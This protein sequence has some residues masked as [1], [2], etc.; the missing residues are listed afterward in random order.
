MSVSAI[1]Q[2]IIDEAR[3]YTTETEE[4]EIL[5]ELQHY[6]GTTNV[7]D[8]TTDYLTALFFAC[9][10]FPLEDGRVIMLSQQ[11]PMRPY[12]TEPRANTSRA[13][14]Q[15]SVFV[16]PPNGFIVPEDVVRIPSALKEPMLRYLHHCHSISSE[17][18]YNDLHGFIRQQN[19]HGDAYRELHLA[20]SYHKEHEGDL[21]HAIDHYTRAVALNPRLAQAY[22]GRG[23]AYLSKGELDRAIQDLTLCVEVE[24]DHSCAYALRGRAH[25]RKGDSEQALQ[26]LD[27]AIN[28]NHEFDN[29]TTSTAHFYRGTAHVEKGDYDEAISDFDVVIDRKLPPN[30]TG[31]Y[32]NRGVAYLSKGEIEQAVKDF[33]RTIELNPDESETFCVRGITHVYR[34]D[35][36][37]ALKDFNRSINLDGGHPCAFHNRGVT[38]LFLSVWDEAMDD[39]SRA[40]KMGIDTESVFCNDF[41][42][43][44]EFE[45]QNG[46]KIPE[47]IAAMLGG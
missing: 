10:G 36:D 5:S 15:K 26:D 32:H 33:D 18:I 12:I 27:K 40:K 21:R 3:R 38:K 20:I 2:E 46:V 34:K 4:I 6:G 41:K 17:S 19:L 25:L 45:K 35:Y 14:V 8:F 7:I 42:S 31:A 9:D 24:E 29:S 16:L 28:L 43:V 13:M 22:C 44:T 23:G 47:E 30:M 1:Q 39:L 37:Q 11:G